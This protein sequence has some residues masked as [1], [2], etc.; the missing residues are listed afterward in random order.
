MHFVDRAVVL[1][2][3]LHE[4]VEIGRPPST[5]CTTWWTSVNSV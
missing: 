1:V 5:Q 2:A 4:I 3:Q